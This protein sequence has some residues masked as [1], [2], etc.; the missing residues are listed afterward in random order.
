MRTRGKGSS[1]NDSELED[2]VLPSAEELEEECFDQSECGRGI[3]VS[4]QPER[5]LE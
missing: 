4:L 5:G 1:D 2:A 3:A